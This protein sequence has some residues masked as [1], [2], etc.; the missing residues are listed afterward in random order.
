MVFLLRVV[1]IP[2]KPRNIIPHNNQ[3]TMFFS[4]AQLFLLVGD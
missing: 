3:L 4:M 2:I 1:I